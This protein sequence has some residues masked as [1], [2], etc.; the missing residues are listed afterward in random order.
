MCRDQVTVRTFS[1]LLSAPQ[2]AASRTHTWQRFASDLEWS[3]CRG[4]RALNYAPPKVV[5]VRLP[6]HLSVLNQS[7]LQHARTLH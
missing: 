7:S 1:V 6:T 4:L 3:R 2:S 5:E